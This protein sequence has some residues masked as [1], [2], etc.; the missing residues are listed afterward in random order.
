MAEVRLEDVSKRF[1]ATT[2]VEGLSLTVADGEFVVLLGPTGA[3][4]T[5][6]L[7][8]VAGLE[9]ADQG[10]ILIGGE[11]VTRADPASR[12][13]TFVF[14]QYSLYPHMTVY[15]NLAFPLRSPAR[16]QSEAAI[17]ARVE[18]VASMLRISSKLGNK[19]TRL[20]GGEMQRVAIG[21]ALVREP[22][23]YLM[24]EPLSSLDAK[25]R[26]EMRLELKRI[27]K[28]LGATILY[29]THDQVEAMTM[30][31]RI[32]VM[33]EGR[34]IQIGSP[35]AIYTDP[36]DIYVATR[37][38]QPSIN[39]VPAGLIPDAGA[40]AGAVTLGLRTEHLRITAKPNGGACG[41]VAW[42]EHLGDQN[43]LHVEI[44]G[45]R[46]TVLADP[47][48][49]L[50]VGDTVG[51]EAVGALYFGADGSRIRGARG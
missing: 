33:R 50:A 11:D 25:L 24:D 10:R 32:G 20:S 42:I 3:G 13:V 1:G 41:T 45:R 28:E 8:L 14:Q 36:D 35:H 21:R 48:T 29:V 18:A 12:D 37:L 30:A 23:V 31:D 44:G 6:T 46:L 2:A 26:S 19:A 16:R 7:R 49:D 4:K 39:L 9:Q 40:P 47:D 15:D 27:K 22:R 34:L 5:T 17:R 51:V 43:H 38:G